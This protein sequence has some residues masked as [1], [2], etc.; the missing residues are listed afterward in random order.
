[1][2]MHRHTA[3]GL[4][5]EGEPESGSGSED[6]LSGMD[7]VWRSTFDAV[8]DLLAV[9]DEN[10]NLLQVN[11]ALL[12]RLGPAGKAVLGR[13]CYEVF[14]QADRPVE[15]CPLHETQLDGLAHDAEVRVEGLGGDYQV[16]T[17]P[18][19]DG[20]GRLRGTVHLAR[21]ISDRRIRERGLQ[22]LNRVVQALS[23]SSQAMARAQDEA[24]Y[25]DEVCRIVVEDCGCFLAWI[26][27]KI[28]DPE[29]SIRPMAWAGFEDGYLSTLGLTWADQERGRGPTGTAI[30]SGQPSLCRNM[31]T[32]PN[33]A[34]WRQEARARGY[35]S[36]L[37][38]P[39]MNGQEVFGALTV[40]S[41][42]AEAFTEPQV[43]VLG[44]LADD[45]AHGILTLRLRDSERR[46]QEAL[47]EST[48]DLKRLNDELEQRVQ[49][50]TADLVR[51]NEALTARILDRDRAL[52][53][54]RESEEKL[55]HAQK[56]EAI[57]TLAGGVAH[58]FNN[59]LQVING[60]SEMSLERLN[61]D[62]PL[63]GHLE[64]IQR[65]G[66]KGAALTRQLLAFSRKQVLAP[67][68]LDLNSLFRE[69]E[70][71]FQRVVK[72]DIRLVFDL[73]P[74]LGPVE[75]DHGQLEQVIMNL[76]VN[77]RDAMPRGGSLTLET[78]RRDG[79]ATFSVTDTGE[80]MPPEV[81]V[82]I[83]EPFYTTKGV[84]KGTGLGLSTAL[85]IVEQSGGTLE[86][87][88]TPGLGTTFTVSLPFATNLEA[89]AGIIP[90]PEPGTGTETVLL[91]EDDEGV[92]QL[93]AHHLRAAGYRVLEAPDAAVA[94]EVLH[95]FE[96]PVHLLL[97]DVVMPGMGGRE[98]AHAVRSLR[99]GTRVVFMSGYPDALAA[100]DEVWTE[101]ILISK[102]F[103]RAKLL[104][105]IRNALD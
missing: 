28:H 91:V 102:P 57:G 78:R 72:E 64:T 71:F 67:E 52:E 66:Q 14:H 5:P 15:N 104:C 53:A 2:V 90:E 45:L 23:R 33:F 98:L 88:S 24:G 41:A 70:K 31:D 62:H 92:R 80:G 21:D 4:P 65:A 17:S 105:M 101:S 75:A 38:L 84:G 6:A 99:P 11:K 95:S 56:M 100:P 48:E 74:G 85:G 81:V 32:D 43:R 20:Q 55:R 49:E 59:L 1:M 7:F 73:E 8:P 54:L 82:R 61:A 60:Y 37:G 27:Y 30:R 16:R 76:V 83:F 47:R 29:L 10:R 97:T 9:L 34:P 46:A 50:R 103:D 69:M 25:L 3:K 35:A 68:I 77:A 93:T 18:I 42:E 87:H 63:R 86:V 26:G 40:Y 39:L 79:F 22:Q 58:D 13:P 36:S 94:L 44:E 51:A 89:K 96:D 12:N 19:F